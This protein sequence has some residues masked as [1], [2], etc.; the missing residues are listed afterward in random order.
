MSRPIFQGSPFIDWTTRQWVKATGRK[1][2][3]REHPWLRAPSAHVDGL[4]GDWVEAEA[5]RSGALVVTS[6]NTGLLPD[7]SILDSEDFK[8]TELRKE[9]VD[10]Y[11][12]TSRWELEVWVQWSRLFFPLAGC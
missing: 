4:A 7:F 3:L 5:E 2:D 10:F 9:I 1:V 12:H 11:Q 8:S 6:P